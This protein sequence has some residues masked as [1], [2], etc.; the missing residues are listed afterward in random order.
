MSA[1][2][3]FWE[4]RWIL[5]KKSDPIKSRRMVLKFEKW[6][7]SENQQ[8]ADEVTKHMSRKD[9]ELFKQLFRQYIN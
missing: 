4:K 5:K 8:M 1:I 9:A 6:N 2:S 7:G 3:N